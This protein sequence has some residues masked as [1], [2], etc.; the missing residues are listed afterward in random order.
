M[1]SASPLVLDVS[2]LPVASELSALTSEDEF[3]FDS[4]DFSSFS[5]SF[6]FS[7]SFSADGEVVSLSSFFAG[8]EDFSP[9]SG[10]SIICKKRRNVRMTVG[11]MKKDKV[12]QTGVYKRKVFKNIEN[13]NRKMK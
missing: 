13:R 10:I 3:S 8:L 7:T 5:P 9:S 4:V 12:R 1:L 11:D 6:S 2:A